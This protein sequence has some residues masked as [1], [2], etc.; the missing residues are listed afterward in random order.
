MDVN[1]KR[2]CSSSLNAERDEVIRLKENL[3][4]EVKTLGEK[5]S[6]RDEEYKKILSDREEAVSRLASVEASVCNLKLLEENLK[7][8]EEEIEKKESRISEEKELMNIVII[9]IL[10]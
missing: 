9:K 5:F 10:Y 3:V 8:R 1:L 6:K 2:F 7:S 4:S